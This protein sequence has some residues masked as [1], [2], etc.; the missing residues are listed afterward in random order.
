[1]LLASLVDHLGERRELIASAS[2]V[3]FGAVRVTGDLC[4][5]LDVTRDGGA[6]YALDGDDRPDHDSHFA[7]PL[8]R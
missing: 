8:R 4:V 5:T 3:V 7:S 2:F 6:P 1:M